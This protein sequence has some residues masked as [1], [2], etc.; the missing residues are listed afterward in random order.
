MNLKI[1]VIISTTRPTRVGDKVGK[2]FYEKVKN[3]PSVAFELIDLQHIDL[4]FLSEP[5]EPS[6]GHYTQ[7]R[8]INWSKKIDELDGFVFVTAEYN[9]GIPAPLKNA[10]DSIYK[11]WNRKPVAFVGYGSYGATRA[12]EQL[13]NVTAKIGMAPLSKTFVSILHPW[14]AIHEDGSIDEKFVNGKIEGLITNLKWWATT[15]KAAR[16]QN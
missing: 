1:G 5:E 8:V 3:T 12:V 11:E 13:V 6:S 2:W 15:L 16:E 7:D 9:N 10:I 4:P 14:E